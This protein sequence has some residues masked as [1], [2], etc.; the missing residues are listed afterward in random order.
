MKFS[1]ISLGIAS[2][3]SVLAA[4]MDGA[5]EK[6]AG[7]L[8]F[9]GA[10]ESGGE[11]GQKNL[12]GQLGKDYTWPN[13]TAIDILR[14]QGLNTFRIGT[15]MERITPDKLTNKINED[16]FS[17][18]EDARVINDVTSKGSYAIFDP[19]NY[20]RY[21]GN[22]ITSP[23]DFGAWWKTVAARFKDNDK[24][25]FD[26]NNEYHDMDNSLVRDLNQAA[27]DN[28]RAAGATKQMIWIEG[29][30]YSGAWHWIESGTGDALKNLSDPTDASG[31][32][33]YYEMHQY[34]DSDGSGTNE[35]CVSSTVGAER[36]AI[37]TKWLKDN[38]K[39]G[40]IGEIGA[41]ANTQCQEAVKGALQ[42]LADNSEQWKGVVWWAAGPWWADYI[43][44][45][46]PTTG[47]A[48]TTYLPILK[49]FA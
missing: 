21:Y 4:P 18:V 12:P 1:S 6:R 48:Y 9:V 43:Y 30:A 10:N 11:F 17:G 2:V 35:D 7:K 27:I 29:N 24:V 40:V 25:I 14:S 8:E 26:T 34:L 45:M 49:T 41:G 33:L 37:A 22:I 20:G 47:K 23:T 19:H 28:I 44:S 15:M 13:K 36:L 5:K 42:H 32:L 31:K 3:V 16:Y 38:N 39:Q 46:E